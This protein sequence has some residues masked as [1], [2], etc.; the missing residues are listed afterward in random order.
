MIIIT[1]EIYAKVTTYYIVNNTRMRANDVSLAR[2][3]HD[4]ISHLSDLTFSIIHL[5]QLNLS[6]FYAV[7]FLIPAYLNSNYRLYNSI[8][9][10]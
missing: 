9:H 5:G 8:E 1:S 6:S 3:I 10:P 7:K 2:L 4:L